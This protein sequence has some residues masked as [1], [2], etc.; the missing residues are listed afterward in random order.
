M[1]LEHPLPSHDTV[2]SLQI[3]RRRERT[4][5]CPRCLHSV[6][7]V[8]LQLCCCCCCCYRYNTIEP[9]HLFAAL[10][11]DRN[12]E[13]QC[14]FRTVSF[15]Y[16]SQDQTIHGDGCYSRMQLQILFVYVDQ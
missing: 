15:L 6:L 3:I 1:E 14:H 16:S 8:C 7:R 2:H 10:P 4:L 9:K 5:L 11:K 12:S 13:G